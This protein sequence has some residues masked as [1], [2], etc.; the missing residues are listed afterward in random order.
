MLRGGELMTAAGF[1]QNGVGRRFDDIGIEGK[2][3]AILLIGRSGALPERFGNYA[4]DGSAI[5]PVMVCADQRDAELA[6]LQQSLAC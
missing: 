6:Y 2:W 5:P 3:D 4:E 1:D